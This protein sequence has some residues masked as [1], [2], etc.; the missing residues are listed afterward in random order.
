[1]IF[2]ISRIFAGFYSTE[3]VMGNREEN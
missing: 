2:L 3:N 1:M